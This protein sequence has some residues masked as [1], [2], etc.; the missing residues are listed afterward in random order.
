MYGVTLI[1]ERGK[2]KRRERST[3]VSFFITFF[4]VSLFL[5]F[6]FL[7]SFFIY[8]FLLSSF[9]FLPLTLLVF[10]FIT[11]SHALSLFSFI[12]LSFPPQF[13]FSFFVSLSHIM[14]QLLSSL[15]LRHNVDT[16]PENNGFDIESK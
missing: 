9:F 14:G 10:I 11:H 6:Y 3:W 7:S 1:G 4:F 12:S 15:N 8:L 2:T 5:F 16:V 13:L